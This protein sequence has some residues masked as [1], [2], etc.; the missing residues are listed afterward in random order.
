MYVYMYIHITE[1]H[2][3][4]TDKKTSSKQKHTRKQQQNNKHN[5]QTHDLFV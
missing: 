5:K 4:A 1:T 2:K 3:T